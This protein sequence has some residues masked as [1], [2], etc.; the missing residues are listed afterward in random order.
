MFCTATVGNAKIAVQQKTSKYIISSIG[1]IPGAMRK[2]M[3]LPYARGVTHR[4]I[5]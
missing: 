3:S 1:A 2:K 5:M 4:S